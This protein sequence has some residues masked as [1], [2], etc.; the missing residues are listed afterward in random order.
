MPIFPIWVIALLIA[1]LLALL[2]YG[3]T[4]LL[5]KRVQ[6]RWIATLGILRVSIIVIF[7]LCLLRPV[8]SY[9]HRSREDPDLLILVDASRS[10]ASRDA[11]AVGAAVGQAR[12]K[13]ALEPLLQG[14]LAP[15]LAG[16]FNLRYFTF[17]RDARPVDRSALRDI[18]PQG[19]ATDIARGIQAAWEQCQRQQTQ[20]GGAGATR[21]I[22]I[23]DGN[24]H[25]EEDPVAVAQRLGLQL[26]VVIP[27]GEPDK[28]PA[29]M[30]SI[31]NVQAARRV[32]I[33]SE[34]R[35]LVVAVAQ[36]R[37]AAQSQDL[38][39]TLL[40]DGQAV[41]SYPVHFAPGEQEKHLSVA[42]RPQ[43]AGVR[44][45]T[46]VLGSAPS[47]GPAAKAPEGMAD[48]G[49]FGVSVQVVG[50][51]SEVLLLEDSWRWTFPYL[52]RIFEDDPSFNFTAFLPRGQRAFVQLGEAGRQ[53]NL[54]GFPQS[55]NEIGW[56]DVIVLG[57]VDVS[58]WPRD[59]ARSIHD[60][61]VEQGKSLIVVA[62]PRVG[63]LARSP[64]LAPLLPVEL[65]GASSTPIEG[66]IDV[67]LTSDGARQSM[68]FAGGAGQG[69]SAG[70]WQKLPPLDR[71][72]PPLRKK[73]AATILLET[74]NRGNDYG[75]LI[76]MAEHT[77]GRGR[78]LFIGTDTLWKWQ[79]LGPMVDNQ[80]TPFTLFWQQALRAMAPRSLGGGADLQVAPDR[81]RYEAGQTVTLTAQLRGARAGQETPLHAVARYGEGQEIPLVF[82]PQ[83]G[84][85]GAQIARFAAPVPGPYTIVT[86][87]Q[88][89]EQN[90]AEQIT[91]IN[92]QP[93]RTEGAEQSI[94]VANLH[95][96]AR[97]TGGQVIDPKDRTTW[98]AAAPGDRQSVLQARSLPL[99]DNFT[100]LILLSALL[101]S[102]WLVRLL[103]GYV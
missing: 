76:V 78:V 23:S 8:V 101:A 35:F 17:D 65:S 3:S 82:S 33:G 11:L 25:G 97:G 77:V 31:A 16:G 92:V 14:E 63:Q 22:L 75:N 52:R 9:S 6:R 66:P 19:D 7:A 5:H 26:N 68:F 72:Y 88:A 47:T 20:G 1:A 86:T 93:P 13:A 37:D 61:V 103:R 50:R 60:L 64:E 4:L 102:D 85:A 32:L 80:A 57:D 87:L 96:I 99:W 71:I 44:Q 24:D 38:N 59:L 49:G 28:L 27:P 34:L 62:G 83:G 58:R 12:L 41:G 91:A 81:T 70:L 79:M 74:P 10:M 30:A 69:Q 84:V 90:L 48:R 89:G 100:L 98:P 56:F 42:H 95:R 46:F 21:A 55:R 53:V 67:R 36:N 73:P 39:M 40:E 43:Q 54:A 45:Y 2:I 94:N 29:A 51:Q 15:H 18:E